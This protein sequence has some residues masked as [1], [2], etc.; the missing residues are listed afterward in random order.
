MSGN[1][2]FR[3]KNIYTH[4]ESMHLTIYT[5]KLQIPTGEKKM[6][7]KK[8]VVLRSLVYKLTCRSLLGDHS[9]VLTHKRSFCLWIY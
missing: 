6:E 4:T 7:T 5:R 2:K 3:A 9:G 1:P 8:K